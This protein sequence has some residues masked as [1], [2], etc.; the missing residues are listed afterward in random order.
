MSGADNLILFTLTVEG[1]LDLRYSGDRERIN[2][3]R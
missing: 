2:L 1:Q 3:S